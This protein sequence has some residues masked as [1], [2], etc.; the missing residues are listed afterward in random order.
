MEDYTFIS[1]PQETVTIIDHILG[2]KAR[3]LT[4]FKGLVKFRAHT[5]TTVE[6]GR[7]GLR[8]GL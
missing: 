4:T 3:F 8:V 5:L 7:K 6:W 2:H 1:R